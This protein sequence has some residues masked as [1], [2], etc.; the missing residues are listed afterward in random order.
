M[1][2]KLLSPSG[3]RLGILMSG[4]PELS[5]GP[6]LILLGNPRAVAALVPE[7]GEFELLLIC[8]YEARSSSTRFVLNVCTKLS[9]A[10]Y[11]MSVAGPAN[12]NCPF[13]GFTETPLITTLGKEVGM[14]ELTWLDVKRANA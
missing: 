14:T 1:G 8:V 9:C 10:L 2:T 12:P 6:K 11:A 5:S 3:A 13:P 4:S 7:F